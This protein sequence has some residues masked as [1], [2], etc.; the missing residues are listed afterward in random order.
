MP[1][2]KAYKSPDFT[3]VEPPLVPSS[4]GSHPQAAVAWS[5]MQA[6]MRGF[7]TEAELESALASL[8]GDIPLTGGITEQRPA[9]E[10]GGQ[11]YFTRF[12]VNLVGILGEAWRTRKISDDALLD[13]N[14]N[15]VNPSY[16]F[17]VTGEGTFTIE[18]QSASNSPVIADGAL[19]LVVQRRPN[20]G[21][22]M[23][24]LATALAD[25]ASYSF[26]N[27]ARI[28]V[29][30][31]G[32]ILLY[33]ADGTAQEQQGLF[34]PNTTKAKPS[35]FMVQV[36]DGQFIGVPNGSYIRYGLTANAVALPPVLSDLAEYTGF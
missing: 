27:N 28:Q 16:S 18:F 5:E 17:Q 22:A 13:A 15:R 20:V 11:Y 6:A 29:L 8:F 14:G 23:I 7:A 31:D 1:R 12:E 3:E 30:G 10:G 34:T 35:G 33:Q 9:M 36:A 4:G 24:S 19:T 21:V 32:S 26:P 2:D 25:N